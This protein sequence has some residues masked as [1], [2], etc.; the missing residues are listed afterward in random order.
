MK[1]KLKAKILKERRWFYRSIKQVGYTETEKSLINT[2]GIDHFHNTVFF[3]LL[4][5]STSED[6]DKLYTA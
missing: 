1:G 5:T 4:I 6:N 3:G 2:G